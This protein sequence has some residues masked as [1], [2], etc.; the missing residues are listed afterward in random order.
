MDSNYIENK[1]K[2]DQ[3]LQRRDNTGSYSK[4]KFN[5][6]TYFQTVS[7]FFQNSIYRHRGVSVI[8]LLVD[9]F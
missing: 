4:E 8:F 9:Q 5:F 6:I 3:K 7:L 2:M 1:I